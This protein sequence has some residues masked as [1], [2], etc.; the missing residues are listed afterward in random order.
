MINLF[1]DTALMSY[2]VAALPFQA[3]ANYRTYSIDFGLFNKMKAN[4]F[5]RCCLIIQIRARHLSTFIYLLSLIYMN[6]FSSMYHMSLKYLSLYNIY[7]LCIYLYIIFILCISYYNI[8]LFIYVYSVSQKK[9][10]FKDF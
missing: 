9:K 8:F 1:Y 2:D 4:H 10:P 3:H 5:A 6:D 7:P